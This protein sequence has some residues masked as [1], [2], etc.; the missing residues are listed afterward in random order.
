VGASP[1]VLRWRAGEQTYPLATERQG[2]ELVAQTAHLGYVASTALVT[3]AAAVPGPDGAELEPAIVDWDAAPARAEFLLR[4]AISVG[5]EA[6][7]MA[8]FEE[9]QSL[10]LTCQVRQIAAIHEEAC[11]AYA[12]AALTAQTVAADS[13]QTLRSLVLALMTSSADL[14]FFGLS[15]ESPSVSS[16]LEAKFAQFATFLEAELAPRRGASCIGSTTTCPRATSWGR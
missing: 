15:C 8:L 1:F 7:A 4:S 9:L 6:Q 13:Y 14:Q 3:A 10:E 11:T 2:D 12:S 5:D 16:L